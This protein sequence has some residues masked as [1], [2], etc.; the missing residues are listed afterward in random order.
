MC[1]SLLITASVYEYTVRGLGFVYLRVGQKRVDIFMLNSR[2]EHG[3]L[4]SISVLCCLGGVVT[5]TV[6]VFISCTNE[7]LALKSFELAVAGAVLFLCGMLVGQYTKRR[8][9]R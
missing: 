7:K 6:G 3:T 1:D 9:R 2:K 8:S 4:I 5:L